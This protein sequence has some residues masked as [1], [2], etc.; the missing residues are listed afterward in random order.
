M[1]GGE[2]WGS[3]DPRKK[4]VSRACLKD[5]I[6]ELHDDGDRGGRGGFPRFLGILKGFT[7]YNLAFIMFDTILG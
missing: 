2:G 7:M 1:I 5:F 3:V 6:R 4:L